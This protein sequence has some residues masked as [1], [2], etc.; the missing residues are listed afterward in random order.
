MMS[1]TYRH[2]SPD[3]EAALQRLMSQGKTPTQVAEALG[4]DL[5]SVARHF[6]YTGPKPSVGRPPALTKKD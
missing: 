3:E 4:R 5:S 2:F 1:G 6:K